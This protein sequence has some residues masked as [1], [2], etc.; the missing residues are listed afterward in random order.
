VDV[1]RTSC[2]SCA[3][4][5]DDPLSGFY[6]LGCIECSARQLAHGIEY[7]RACAAGKL[8]PEYRDALRS[9]FGDD[10][11]VGH[12]LVKSWAQRIDAARAEA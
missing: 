9:T 2:T 11:E 7:T 8:L 4:A 3:A 10:W 12:R 1:T 6:H 5:A